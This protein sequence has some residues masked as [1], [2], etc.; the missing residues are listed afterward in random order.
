G[1][2]S[3]PAG[4]THKYPKDAALAAALAAR[5]GNDNSSDFDPRTE[6]TLNAAVNIT[7]AER[8]TGSS[9]PPSDPIIDVSRVV[10]ADRAP[11]AFSSEKVPAPP[12]LPLP[13]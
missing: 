6:L 7:T 1:A 13:S 8:L 4:P 9:A 11:V 12:Q 2:K 5:T 10:A 3:D